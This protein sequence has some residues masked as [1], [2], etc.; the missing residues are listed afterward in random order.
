VK[1]HG[2]R[3]RVNPSLDSIAIHLILP[4][5]ILLITNTMERD[6]YEWGKVDPSMFPLNFDKCNIYFDGWCLLKDANDSKVIVYWERI[7]TT[8]NSKKSMVIS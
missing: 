2:H 4:T 5:Q 7:T 1:R 8:T 6:N 3:V